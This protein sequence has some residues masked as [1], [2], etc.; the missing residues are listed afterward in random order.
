M[1][2]KITLDRDE[3]IGCQSCVEIC[4]KVFAF[5]EDEEKA[6]VID[7]E[8]EDTDDCAEEAA[9][10]CPAGCITVEE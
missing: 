1:A 7:T 4:P 3:C 2:K 9:G 5:D 10:S 8:G 6:Y